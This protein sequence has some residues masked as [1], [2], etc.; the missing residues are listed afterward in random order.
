MSSTT[1]TITLRKSVS[2]RLKAHQSCVRGLGLR[3]I[4]QSV[5]LPKTDS[6]MGMVK[7]VQYLLDV[8]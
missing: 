6:I 7:K 1:V 4:G 3:K 2:G 5:E 8:E